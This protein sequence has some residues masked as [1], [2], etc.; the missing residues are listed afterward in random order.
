VTTQHPNHDQLFKRL[1]H[2][3]FP[4]F[5]LLVAPKNAP[6]L[7]LEHGRFVDPGTFTDFPRGDRRHL[8]LV[9]QT[10][11]LGGESKVIFVH[12]E[13][14]AEFRQSFDQR[15]WEYA[16]TLALRH[17]H[18]VFPIALFLKGGP[19]G[20]ERRTFEM[21][22]ADFLVHRF[23]YLA[24]GLSRAPAEIYLERRDPL[25][26]ALAARMRYTQ[27][28]PAEH[29][30][31][32]LRRIAEARD[33]NA[34]RS[35]QLAHIVDTY[36]ELPEQDEI[37]FQEML[38]KDDNREVQT[39]MDLD[40]ADRLLGEGQAVGRK[41]GREEGRSEEAR[42]TLLRLLQ[43]RFGTLPDTAVQRVEG[44]GDLDQLHTW[45]DGVLTAP[46]LKTLGLA[47]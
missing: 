47:R 21:R 44:C 26:A 11:E 5:L 9:Y 37:K 29:K 23:H 4:E 8:D 2:N 18:P 34:A 16:M 41:E 13:V 43:L 42:R 36:L 6:L 1:L 24:F 14:E 30:V 28:P 31:R 12:V 3:F 20:I 40:W 15:M 10:Q 39:M 45:C 22:A 19:P 46:D 32:C 38:S 35:F 27:G 7:R 17:R 25:A 33:L